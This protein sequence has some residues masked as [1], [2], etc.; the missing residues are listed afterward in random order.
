MASS[1]RKRK[2]PNSS[3]PSS[4]S[5]SRSQSQ[6]RNTTSTQE[7][8]SDQTKGE[9]NDQ[10]TS[11]APIE[12]TDEE[13]LVGYLNPS[14]VWQCHKQHGIERKHYLDE[15]DIALARDLANLLNV[16]C[17]ITL[18]LLISG[19]A[20]LAKIVV[21]ID[22][23]TENLST[24]ISGSKYP[25]ALKN[26]CRIGLK[27]TNKDEYFK[28]AQW[29]P[30]WISEAIRLTWEM[31]LTFFKPQASAPM[32]SSLATTSSKAKTSMLAGLS[33]AAAARGGHCSSDPL[34]V[35]LAGGLILDNNEPINPLKWWIQQKRAGNTHGVSLRA[36][37][38]GQKTA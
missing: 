18:Q 28:L 31:W 38:A 13:D 21:F 17:K 25:P 2:K 11:T 4:P 9:D 16:F 15:S 30:E 14:L 24:V 5:P 36:S 12:T 37:Q 6:Q 26:A 35:W 23:I 32:N 29:E 3:H 33:S 27:I 7:N 19:S 1:T 8:Q 34:E 20:R 10:P 22:Q